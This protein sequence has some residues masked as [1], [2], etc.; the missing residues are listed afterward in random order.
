MLAQANF[1]GF[2]TYLSGYSQ[3]MQSFLQEDFA[4][5]PSS[6]RHLTRLVED[7]F[8]IT[9]VCDRCAQHPLIYLSGVSKEYLSSMVSGA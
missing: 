8:A 1:T 7:V 2:Q 5:K 9:N 6:G 4:Q 3:R